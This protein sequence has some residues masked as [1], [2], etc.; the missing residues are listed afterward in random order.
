MPDPKLYNQWKTIDVVDLTGHRI[1]L[2]AC[3]IN[4]GTIRNN[5]TVV[6]YVLNWSTDI[7]RGFSHLQESMI[8]ISKEEHARLLDIER[9]VKSNPGKYLRSC[10]ES[11]HS[12]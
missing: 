11:I 3:C 10:A 7:M 4:L 1:C 9:D 12:V 2:P 5:E 8:Y 6:A